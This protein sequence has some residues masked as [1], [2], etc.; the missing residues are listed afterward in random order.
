MVVVVVVVVWSDVRFFM[1]LVVTTESPLSIRVC[2]WDIYTAAWFCQAKHV[3]ACT[4]SPKSLPS[5]AS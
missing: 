2:A 5:K 1:E 4:N 3:H